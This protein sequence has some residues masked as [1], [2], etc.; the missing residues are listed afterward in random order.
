[1]EDYCSCL[2]SVFLKFFFVYSRVAFIVGF[3][4][5][6]NWGFMIRILGGL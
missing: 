1:M 2:L 4:R 5:R 6:G 3:F